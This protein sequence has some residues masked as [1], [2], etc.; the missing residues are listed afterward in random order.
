LKKAGDVL[1]TWSAKCEKESELPQPLGTQT[2]NKV[3]GKRA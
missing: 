2:K 3:T 1:D